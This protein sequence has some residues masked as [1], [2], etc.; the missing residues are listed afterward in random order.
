MQTIRVKIYMK[1][2]G[3]NEAGVLQKLFDIREGIVSDRE[4][5]YCRNLKELKM[6][7]DAHYGGS[8]IS[9]REGVTHGC[10]GSSTGER[11]EG[12]TLW[13]DS[14]LFPTRFIDSEGDEI[15][16]IEQLCDEYGELTEIDADQFETIADQTKAFHYK[17]D[18]TYNY[19]GHD[20]DTPFDL[21]H[22][23][24]ALYSTCEDYSNEV[25]VAIKFHHGG[26]PRGNYSERVLYRFDSIDE[27]YSALYPT[28]EL[29]EEA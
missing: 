14:S 11:F 1:D 6:V 28:C 24:F 8:Q 26:D 22:A 15:V 3:T 25:F 5:D 29:K 19:L 4:I 27:V 12:L 20:S 13:L 23:D 10:Y 2:H 9:I 16:N 17:A 7:L 21:C 18:N